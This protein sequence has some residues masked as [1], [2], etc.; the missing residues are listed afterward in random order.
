MMG[1]TALIGTL[2]SFFSAFAIIK[3]VF[4]AE[5]KVNASKFKNLY[6]QAISGKH[7]VFYDEVVDEN[8]YPTMWTGLVFNPQVW[9]FL[10]AREQM[11][12]AGAE[13]KGTV[14]YIKTL[15]WNKKKIIRLIDTIGG[16]DKELPIELCYGYNRD[17]IGYLHSQAPSPLQEEKYWK[18]IDEEVCKVHNG[19]L[20]KL[21]ILIYGS[22]GNGKTTF[23]KY[24]AT[25]YRFPIQIVTLTART[26]PA[27][28]MLMFSQ[29]K[30]HSIVLIE[31]FD[32]IFNG[33]ELVSK[34]KEPELTF[35]SLLNCLDGVFND[36]K[37]NLFI[38]TVN[39]I[40][41]VDEA[42][43]G[44]P[45]RFKYVREFPNPKLDIIP[46]EWYTENLNLDQ[47]LRLKEFKDQGLS[48]EEAYWRL[49]LTE[50]EAKPTFFENE[51]E[52][53]FSNTAKVYRRELI[54]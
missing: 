16:D 7:F 18:D 48:K 31:D 8:T 35:D 34:H 12:Q 52:S 4:I 37:Q 53:I 43:K 6:R 13:S 9:F 19:E 42:L 38:F 20:K 30:P 17:L 54:E 22:P 23:V 11:Y 25:K 14:V 46:T 45:S 47:I 2:L 33:R 49:S 28:L 44:R 10:D 32:S 15:K 51:D 24:L 27:Q 3:Y 41:K 39:D 21:G 26:S 50:V 40:S 5:F 29:I 1:W 36:Y